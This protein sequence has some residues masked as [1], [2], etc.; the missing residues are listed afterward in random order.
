MADASRGMAVGPNAPAGTRVALCVGVASYASSPL[1]NSVNDA[2]DMAAALRVVGFAVTLLEDPV[3][4]QLLDAVE[5]FGA[6]LR[7]GG[8]ALFFFAGHGCQSEDGGNYLIPVEE[9]AKDHWLRAKALRCGAGR[10]V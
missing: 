3:L 9:V 1:R 2:R 7:P 5:A 6:A 8:V 10:G 4:E